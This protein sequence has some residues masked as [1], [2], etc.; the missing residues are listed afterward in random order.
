MQIRLPANVDPRSPRASMLN[1]STPAL[2]RSRN[3]AFAFLL[4]RD[5]TPDDAGLQ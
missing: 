4:I 1:D 2:S 3:R 5:H